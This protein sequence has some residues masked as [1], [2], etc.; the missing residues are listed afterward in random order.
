MTSWYD[1]V[2]GEHYPITPNLFHKPTFCSW[3][4]FGFLGGEEVKAAGVA[5]I[6]LHDRELLFKSWFRLLG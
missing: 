5:N 3:V 2:S 1:R 4:A 6:G